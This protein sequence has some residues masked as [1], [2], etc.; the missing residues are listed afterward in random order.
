VRTGRWHRTR[1]GHYSRVRC[2][3]TTVSVSDWRA[4]DAQGASRGLRPVTLRVC[5]TLCA[6]VRCAPDASGVKP[7]SVRC[8][9]CRR[10]RMVAV[11][12]N[13]RVQTASDMWLW[14]EHRTLGLSI[15]WLPAVSP[16]PPRLLPSDGATASLALGAINRSAGRPWLALSTLGT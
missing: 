6:W 7:P 12:G 9:C 16:V 13:G 3:V 15:R 11:G 5:G 14:P 2:C 1:T 10:A 4:P 8:G